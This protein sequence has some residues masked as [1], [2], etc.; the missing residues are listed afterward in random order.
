M[1]KLLIIASLAVLTGCK[2]T[3][4]V[5]VPEYHT[6]TLRVAQIVTDSVYK[7]DSI[8][9]RQSGD[10][11]LIEKWHTVWQNHTAHD[12]LYKSR[13]DTIAKPYPV[14]KEV[15]AE[16]SWWQKT[17]MYAGD[18]LLLL[19]LVVLGFLFVRKRIV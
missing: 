11:V 7:H 1:K 10:T 9:I 19:L 15:P 18:A 17:Q 8:Y 4:Y 12:T 6:D 2:Q 16:L 14:I 13:V 5:V 3:E